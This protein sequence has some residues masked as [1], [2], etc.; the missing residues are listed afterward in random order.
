VPIKMGPRRA[1]DPPELTA[2]PRKAMR[3]LGWTPRVS[4][5]DD[6]IGTA[7]RWHQRDRA[8][9]PLEGAAS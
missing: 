9:A 3:E 6:I 7:W 8:T 2:D 5:V 1:G 4:S